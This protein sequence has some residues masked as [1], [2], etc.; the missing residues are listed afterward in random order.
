MSIALI[1][2]GMGTG[3]ERATNSPPS[4]TSV[5]LWIVR[6]RWRPS[7]ANHCGDR[8]GS[9]VRW[10]SVPAVVEVVEAQRRVVDQRRWNLLSERGHEAQRWA[11]LVE[12][13]LEELRRLH[14]T[15]EDGQSVRGGESR[16]QQFVIACMGVLPEPLAS[17]GEW[18]GRVVGGHADH[19][20][21][22]GQGAKEQFPQDVVTAQ[23]AA[24][25]GHPSLRRRGG[26]T[27]DGGRFAE[28]P[29]FPRRQC[30]RRIHVRLGFSEPRTAAQKGRDPIT[31]SP[32]AR[33]S[34]H[35]ESASSHAQV[36]AQRCRLG[37]SSEN[38]PF[39]GETA[40]VTAQIVMSA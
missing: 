30:Q 35:R 36:R 1:P 24:E 6:T 14:A 29:G 25:N 34:A 37:L 9:R 18:L 33:R 17:V 15:R 22:A 40:A 5:T 27:V 3:C 31:P 4:I 13:Q 19:R 10:P 11:P 16:H 21:A 32:E 12:E 26:S 2:R 20:H 8:I 23:E 38:S 7:V 39:S 28:N